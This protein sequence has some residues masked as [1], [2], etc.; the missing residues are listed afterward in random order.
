V[1]KACRSFRL[2]YLKPTPSL[3]TILQQQNQRCRKMQETSLPI[4]IVVKPLE[5][6]R[7]NPH[8]SDWC[9]LPYPNHPKG[10]PNFNKKPTCPPKAKWIEELVK[11]PYFLVGVKFNLKT[12]IT[13]MRAKHPKWSEKQLKC[14]L[15]WQPHINKKLRQTAERLASQIPNSTVLYTPEANGVHI[16][17]TCETIGITL[18]RNPKNYVWKIAIIGKKR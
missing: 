13:R 1:S 18:E 6:I 17:K 9:Q 4:E 7:L 16:F 15:Y 8:T 12:H 14:L 11:P 5:V 2:P 3:K 10:C